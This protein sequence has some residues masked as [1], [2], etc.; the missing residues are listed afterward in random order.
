MNVIRQYGTGFLRSLFLLTC[1]KFPLILQE[2]DFVL[3]YCLIPYLR[4]HANNPKRQPLYCF[5]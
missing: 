2:Y 1:R 4:E 3:L 5:R